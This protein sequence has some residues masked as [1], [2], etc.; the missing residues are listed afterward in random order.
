[1]VLLADRCVLAILALDSPRLIVT[2]KQTVLASDHI[3][4]RYD[5]LRSL[6]GD[7][8]PGD[9]VKVKPAAGA[10]LD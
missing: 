3:G 7:E 6:G 10:H 8:T 1:M 9:D 4:H 2:R 5:C